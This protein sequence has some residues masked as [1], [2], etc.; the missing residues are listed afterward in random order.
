MGTLKVIATSAKYWILLA[1][2]VVAAVLIVAWRLGSGRK[3]KSD[4]D[5]F[6]PPEVLRKAQEKAEEKA[7]VARAETKVRT[8]IQ[9]KELE[10]ITKLA[11]G[12]DRRKRLAEFLNT[13]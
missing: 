8:G 6:E 11:D 9:K 3:G 12:K 4:L 1:V 5:L 2:G 7:L 10:D 13:V